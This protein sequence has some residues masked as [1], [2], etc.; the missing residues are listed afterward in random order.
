MGQAPDV[1]QDRLHD[2]ARL[3]R[4]H[5]REEPAER[6][7]LLH[8]RPRLVATRPGLDLAPGELAIEVGLLDGGEPAI[9]GRL[10]VALP[11][12]EGVRVRDGRTRDAEDDRQDLLHGIALLTDDGL[13]ERA[14]E[15][16]VRD[17]EVPRLLTDLLRGSRREA[18]VELALHGGV[19]ATVDLLLHGASPQVDLHEDRGA[20]AVLRVRV[21]ELL[22][23]LGDRAREDARLRTGPPGVRD[24]GDAPGDDLLAQDVE[25]LG[26]DGVEGLDRRDQHDQ[27]VAGARPGR[28]RPDVDEQ[29]VDEL[30]TGVGGRVGGTLDVDHRGARGEGRRE[31][32]GILL[33]WGVNGRLQPPRLTLRILRRKTK[34]VNSRLRLENKSHFFFY[35]V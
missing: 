17:G 1:G 28:E 25:L 2:L 29:V 4:D 6:Q 35:E 19:E 5:G 30:P 22:H 20:V 14:Q 16:E 10:D 23:E 13:V 26:R 8:E 32:H 15:H 34:K 18:P 11:R 3:A 33:G 7:V 24:L 21:G 27:Q 31:I 9:E 12:L